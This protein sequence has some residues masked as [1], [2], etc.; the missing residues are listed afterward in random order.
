DEYAALTMVLLRLLAFKPASNVSA[1]Q[2]TPTEKKT[3][4]TDAGVPVP[5]DGAVSP[6]PVAPG[7]VVAA[8]SQPAEPGA[9]RAFAPA[10]TGLEPAPIVQVQS[11][12]PVPSFTEPTRSMPAI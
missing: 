2:P 3:L 8:V 12:V 1:V 6:Q 11:V 4:K 9:V 7:P 5:K 10:V